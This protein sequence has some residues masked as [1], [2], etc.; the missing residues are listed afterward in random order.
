VLAGAAAAAVW[1]GT[2][3]EEH[4]GA[5]ALL[6]ATAFAAGCVLGHRAAPSAPAEEDSG[7]KEA[8]RVETLA[9]RREVEALLSAVAH[10]LRSPIGAVLN[11]ATV[12]ELDHGPQLDE[13]GREVVSRIRR[14]AESGLS[15]LDALSRLTAVS[16]APLR[17]VSVEIEP[18]VRRAYAEA[19]PG[20]ARPPLSVNPLPAR[21]IADPELLRIAFGELFDNALKFSGERAAPSISVGGRRD[22]DGA[23]VYW[24]ADDGAGFDMRFAGKL[25]AAFERLHSRE[26]FPGAGVGL[27]VVRRIAERHGG[28]AWAEGE[29]GGGARVFLSL[30]DRQ[31]ASGCA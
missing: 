14:S 26:E 4:A 1:S 8:A 15:L 13:G 17:P 19:R 9:T 21:A 20:I 10:D 23:L 18:L 11:F 22:P 28:R 5:V 31:E 2:G 12:L 27:A 30:P 16:R 7:A 29:T 25:F 3:S 6:A 24:V